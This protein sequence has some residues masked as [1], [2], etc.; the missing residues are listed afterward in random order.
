M[1]WDNLI[2]EALHYLQN[3]IFQ[4]VD[5]INLMESDQFRSLATLL[6]NTTL[7]TDIIQ[8]KL[9]SRTHL[10]EGLLEFFPKN[11]KEPVANIAD[12]IQ[13]SLFS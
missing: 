7:P 8:Q 12:M 2:V 9:H 6:F 11:C 10:F 4:V 5:H 1:C 3:D 13:T